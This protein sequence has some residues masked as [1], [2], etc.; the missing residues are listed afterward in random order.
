MV[1]LTFC[2]FDYAFQG[3][4]GVLDYFGMLTKDE[5]LLNFVEIP[6]W[7]GY[8]DL[9]IAGASVL[10]LLLVLP[11][12]IIQIL[13]IIKTPKR[14]RAESKP[15]VRHNTGSFGEL[16]DTG[17]MLLMPS[18]EWNPSAFQ[19][20]SSFLLNKDDEEGESCCSPR[21]TKESSNEHL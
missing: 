9:V 8:V 11:I 2:I 18:S 13:N 1:F 7:K 10:F 6:E 5:I 14:L 20:P 12:W 17:S 21:Q 3:A 16:S 19:N 15:L 4:V